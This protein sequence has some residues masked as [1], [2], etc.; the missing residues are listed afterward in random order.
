MQLI[1]PSFFESNCFSSP[2]ILDETKPWGRFL[3]KLFQ[4]SFSRQIEGGELYHFDTP[5]NVR[6]SLKISNGF[7]NEL[8][9]MDPGASFAPILTEVF[10]NPSGEVDFIRKTMHAN[11]SFGCKLRPG[12]NDRSLI[13]QLAL[14]QVFGPNGT[15]Q[16]LREYA[17][18]AIAELHVHTE[19]LIGERFHESANSFLGYGF[20]ADG[21]CKGDGWKG[22]PVLHFPGSGRISILERKNSLETVF[23][24]PKDIESEDSIA[25][26]KVPYEVVMSKSDITVL[27]GGAVV[28]PFSILDRFG[29]PE[30]EEALYG[31][32][33][34]KVLDHTTESVSR[35][36][37]PSPNN[38]L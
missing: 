21:V 27:L 35:A 24:E 11:R 29:L 14:R 23:K 33:S 17:P 3:K 26:G 34:E 22:D 19:T 25:A 9:W 15:P 36:L 38:V 31:K 8:S 32:R 10:F 5:T 2:E 6:G 28:G 18:N 4:S 13:A 16:S 12:P 37:V 20:D 30:V 7:L 1:E